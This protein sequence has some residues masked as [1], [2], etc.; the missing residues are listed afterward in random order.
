MFEDE[1]IQVL[2]PMELFYSKKLYL[3]YTALKL[4]LYSPALYKKKYINKQQDDKTSANLVEGKVIHCLM[5]NNHLFEEL[6]IISPM[7]L[8]IGNNKIVIDKVFKEYLIIKDLREGPGNFEEQFNVVGVDPEDLNSYGNIII[9]ILSQINLHQSLTDDKKADKEGIKKTGDEKRLEKMI[10]T[11]NRNYFEFL[12]VRGSKDLIDQAT[13][14]YCKEAAKVL[15]DN[16][17]IRK[18]LGMD[19][20]SGINVINE[21]EF[22][23][24]LDKYPFGL[25]GI[26]DNLVID[27]NE[28]VIR[29]ND[30]KTTGKSLTDFK[31]TVDFFQYW[32]QAVIYGILI[33]HTYKELIE[34]GFRMEFRFIV[35]DGNQQ[36]YPFLVTETTMSRWAVQAEELFQAAEFHYTEKSYNLP[37]MFEKGLVTL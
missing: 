13:Y 1:V 31:D 36:F 11:E 33:Y 18:L 35:I 30:L 8:P 7:N 3:S 25:K 9:N 14:D 27:Y 5:L 10:T 22:R 2:D 34:E 28:K 16:E 12:K 29:V 19:P 24:E 17:T 37:L 21:Q 23:V 6:F 4:M 15:S 20:I 32:L 26:I